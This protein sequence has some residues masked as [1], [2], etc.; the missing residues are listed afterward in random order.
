MND[1]SQ[2]RPP[3]GSWPRTYLLVCAVAVAVIA[4]LWWLTAA[5]DKGRVG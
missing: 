5:F 2:E 3:F 4:V 1:A